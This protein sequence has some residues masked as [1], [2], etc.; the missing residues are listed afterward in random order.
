MYRF[1]E[2]ES[3]LFRVRNGSQM[4]RDIEIATDRPI[5]V[6]DL[7]DQIRNIVEELESSWCG[8]NE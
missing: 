8:A 4:F 2:N 6:D 5:D 1:D 3:R 7:R